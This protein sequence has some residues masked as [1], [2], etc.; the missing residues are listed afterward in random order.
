[1]AF[2]FSGL[3]MAVRVPI[4][5]QY[6]HQY[7]LYI[8]YTLYKLRVH[9]DP[10]GRQR[11][12]LPWAFPT[13]VCNWMSIFGA[14][15]SLALH[16][17][18]GTT[19]HPALEHSLH[20]VDMG[21]EGR[22]DTPPPASTA[23][24]TTQSAA[25]VSVV[26]CDVTTHDVK[27][28]GKTRRP[29]TSRAKTNA[30]RGRAFRERRLKHTGE[31]EVEIYRL[32]AHIAELE[33]VRDLWQNTQL[34]AAKTS[35][36]GSLV[37]LVHEYLTLFRF[38]FRFPVVK[39]SSHSQQRPSLV[40]PEVVQAKICYQEHFLRRVMAHDARVGESIGPEA[41]IS[42]WNGYTLAHGNQRIDVHHVSAIG[43]GDHL[44]TEAH[45]TFHG[46]ITET[47]FRVLYPRALHRHDLQAIFLHRDVAFRAVFRHE[48]T[49]DGQIQ[50]EGA[51]IAFV[52]G[53]LATGA[54]LPDVMELLR[55]SIMTP[56]NTIAER[57]EEVDPEICTPVYPE[58]SPRGPENLD[59]NSRS[60]ISSNASKDK[61]RMEFLLADE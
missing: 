28:A 26:G 56:A 5:D 17:G 13:T 40:S 52:D 55:L 11:C 33:S 46:K 54:S 37:R 50:Y 39:D 34:H 42:N 36:T 4:T 10:F 25:R 48:F 15:R 49:P 58:S 9:I 14:S 60:S 7:G 38:G 24:E 21:S 23:V 47:T 44:V 18:E 1:M 30:E 22:D 53:L 29:R 20:R 59:E 32:R 51:D 3:N 43:S 45:V 16:L 8:W 41:S 27:A 19:L 6:G 31:L 57:I 35:D 61:L 12:R 2:G